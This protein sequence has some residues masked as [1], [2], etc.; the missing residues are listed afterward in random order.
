MGVA[1]RALTADGVKMDTVRRTIGPVKGWLKRLPRY[2]APRAARP[3]LRAPLRLLRWRP[4]RS[5]TL[6]TLALRRVARRAERGSSDSSEAERASATAFAW[7]LRGHGSLRLG[8]RPARGRASVCVAVVLR[9]RAHAGRCSASHY[10]DGVP[11]GLTVLGAR[12]S[13]ELLNADLE[14][15]NL[16]TPSD[17]RLVTVVKLEAISPRSQRRAQLADAYPAA[18]YPSGAPTSLR[19]FLSRMRAIDNGLRAVKPPECFK[20]CEHAACARMFVASP[21]R[22][23][24]SVGEYMAALGCPSEEAGFERRFCSRACA[25]GWRLGP[26]ARRPAAARRARVPRAAPRARGVWRARAP[27]SSRPRSRVTVPSKKTHLRGLRRSA[28]PR[29]TARRCAN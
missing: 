4:P 26:H 2:R 3:G 18:A 27:P 7:V 1:Y 5:S 13:V 11:V 20:Q 16:R 14:L 24:G 12:L 19:V 25:H 23:G 28:S 15:M 22:G 10:Y 17:D 29:W 21:R 6:L 8:A 9:A